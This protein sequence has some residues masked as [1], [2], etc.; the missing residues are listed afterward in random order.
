GAAERCGGGGLGAGRG[1]RCVGGRGDWGA[2]RG[3]VCYF[4]FV[5]CKGAHRS[6][7]AAM[8]YTA[9]RSAW[10]RAQT[11]EPEGSTVACFPLWGNP[12]RG[13]S[14]GANCILRPRGPAA[15]LCSHGQIR[16][17]LQDAGRTQPQNRR[18]ASARGRG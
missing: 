17:D 1:R 11:R 4:V 15:A 7:G 14:V 16:G 12:K 10:V 18:G 2:G 8:G 9:L 3:W 5:L 13:P 6:S